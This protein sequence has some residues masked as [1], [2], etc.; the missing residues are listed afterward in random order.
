MKYEQKFK[1][2]DLVRVLPDSEPG[3]WGD[4]EEHDRYRENWDELWGLLGIV[5]RIDGWIRRVGGNRHEHG[6]DIWVHL[7]NGLDNIFYYTDELE[8][9]TE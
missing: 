9:A 3:F 8:K 5:T 1:I 7:Q 2:G 6:A 4:E